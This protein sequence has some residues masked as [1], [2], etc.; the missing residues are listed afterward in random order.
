MT[1]AYATHRLSGVASPA[2]AAYSA[3]ELAFQLKNSGAKVLFTVSQSDRFMA[4]M[5]SL[6]V[7]STSR[8]CSAGCKVF[9][10]PK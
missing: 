8:N 9:W 10:H 1:L 2:N 4:H 7:C 6:K 5:L 3:V